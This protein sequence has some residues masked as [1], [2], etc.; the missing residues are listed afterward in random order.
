MNIQRYFVILCIF[1][2]VSCMETGDPAFPHELIVEVVIPGIE[3]VYVSHITP[4]FSPLR[5]GKS[6]DMAVS[7]MPLRKLAR[8]SR[9]CCWIILP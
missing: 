2:L 9:L 6:S 4:E 7:R 1:L 3:H 5:Q 8:V